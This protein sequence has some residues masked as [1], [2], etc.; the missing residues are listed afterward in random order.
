MLDKFFILLFLGAMLPLFCQK[1]DSIQVEDILIEA[2]RYRPIDENLRTAK[3]SDITQ[4]LEDQTNLFL[5]TNGAGTSITTSFLGGNAS[6]TTITVNGIPFSNPLIG[7]ADFS[8][9]K[10][11]PTKGRLI[12]DISEK[13]SNDG[14]AGEV[15]LLLDNELEG[16]DI[17]LQ[18]KT[19]HHQE[20]RVRYNI[21]KENWNF[22][23]SLSTIQAD[24]NYPFYVPQLNETR[25]QEDARVDAWTSLITLGYNP[26]VQHKLSAFAWYH[27]QDRRIPPTLTQ[28]ENDQFQEDRFIRTGLNWRMLLRENILEVKTGFSDQEINFYDFGKG[29]LANF[30]QY[31]GNI[32]FSGQTL[33]F[34]RQIELE[35]EHY[36]G[37][38]H[39]FEQEE[40][41]T[42]LRGKLG[43]SKDIGSTN[44]ELNT[45]LIY[46]PHVKQKL[47][48]AGQIRAKQDVGEGRVI[49][50]LRRL[51]RQPAMNDL[52]WT[53]GGNLELS[54]ESGFGLA[55]GY[56]TQKPFTFRGQIFSRW[57]RNYIIWLP[58][59]NTFLWGASNIDNVWSR[60]I[61]L[62]FSK[63]L[64][65]GEST[66]TLLSKQQL[67]Y[68]SPTEK[69]EALNIPEYQQLIYTPVHT[70]R[71]ALAFTKGTIEIS[72]YVRTATAYQGINEEV[73]SQT[74]V[75][76]SIEKTFNISREHRL[77]LQL[78][79]DNAFDIPYFVVE[80]RPMPGRN[81]YIKV[82]YSHHKS[83]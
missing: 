78:G 71:N 38:N 9:L 22:G 74:V 70:M 50:S 1:T 6:Q 31:F 45:D 30:E 79:V 53:G 57:V 46:S 83:K 69:V 55:L 64:Y 18:S 34:D 29:F 81:G 15:N 62:Q 26:S 47:N 28:Q 14:V 43:L 65:L 13:G 11:L 16:F 10:G 19:Y 52:F 37:D 3:Q 51:W 66:L 35:Y 72:C 63:A 39:S 60:G 75:D 2:D 80:R 33:G 82:L 36:V 54:P 4:I 59:N 27:S 20:G 25:K 23:T 58:D 24:N 76:F 49:L 42:V 77:Q 12:D 73:P 5:K 8:L 44:V 56:K 41:Q 21:V 17:E 67:V 68:S 61:D 48:L 32:S 40:R 7:Q